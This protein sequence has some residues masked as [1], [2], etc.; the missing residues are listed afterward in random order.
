MYPAPSVRG[1]HLEYH[2]WMN[3]LAFAKEEIAIFEKHLETMVR[4]YRDPEVLGRVA[5]FRNRFIRHRDLAGGL[6]H[7]LH[8]CEKQLADFVREMSGM[9]ID[10]VRMD[11]HGKLREEMRGFH[12][13]FKVLKNEFRQFEAE[14]LPAQP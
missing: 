9:G 1:L 2:L 7:R 10:S 13:I 12:E 3:E 14:P 4:A 5:H 8:E 11:N 6:S